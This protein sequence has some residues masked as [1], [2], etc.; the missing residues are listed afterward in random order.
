MSI[1]IFE[2]NVYILPHILCIL[3]RIQYFPTI[4][5]II[6]F[7]RADGNRCVFHS[8][9]ILSDRKCMRKCECTYSITPVQHP[10]QY[11]EFPFPSLQL[12]SAVWCGAALKPIT[13]WNISF[14]SLCGAS[15]LLFWG[16]L[17][18]QCA[19]LQIHDPV[20][21]PLHQCSD[22]WSWTCYC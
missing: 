4:I 5:R 15:Y 9:A 7:V 13:T 16:T 12:F 8:V 22:W 17:L 11:F 21:V 1:I 19:L 18:A 6:D 2:S 10:K 20:A 14:Q 3:P